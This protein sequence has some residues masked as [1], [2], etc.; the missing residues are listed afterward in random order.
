MRRSSM[1]SNPPTTGVGRPPV[2]RLGFTFPLVCLGP[3]S[4]AEARSCLAGRCRRLVAVG[5]EHVDVTGHCVVAGLS[6]G[7][8]VRTVVTQVR[9]GVG[10][11]RG[12]IRAELIPP[13]LAFC[14]SL[15]S[16]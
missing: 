8:E 7:R 9:R 2:G 6:A 3:R 15:M 5:G 12:G 16:A 10:V 14:V 11:E 4:V 1:G 13:V